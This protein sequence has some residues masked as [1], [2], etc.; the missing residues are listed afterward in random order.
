MRLRWQGVL[1]LG[2]LLICSL[3]VGIVWFVK[4]GGINENNDQVDDVD[5]LLEE[6]AALKGVV[7]S[8]RRKGKL[9]IAK[10]GNKSPSSSRLLS[11]PSSAAS[12][13]LLKRGTAAPDA[14]LKALALRLRVNAAK[15]HAELRKKVLHS[16]QGLRKKRKDGVIM[17]MDEIAR[18]EIEMAQALIRQL[19]VKEYGKGP[20]RVHIVVRFPDGF[21]GAIK[22]DLAPIEYVP[23]SVWYFLELVKGFKEGAFHRLAHVAQGYLHCYKD[24]EDICG[25]GL[26][27]Q[28]YDKRW[29]HVKDSLGFAGRPGGQGGAFYISIIDNTNNHGPGTQGSATEADSCFGRLVSLDDES[30]DVLRRLKLLDAPSGGNGF[31]EDSKKWPIIERVVLIRGVVV[32]K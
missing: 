5:V 30:M 10:A 23:Y 31:I 14:E 2:V 12:S 7:R 24:S 4:K 19:I 25:Q 26:A 13:P 27:F 15:P 22:V 16:L 18:V 3:L 1:I 20:F 17:E 29:P 9:G 8:R 28:E 32:A 6:R 11:T 21:R